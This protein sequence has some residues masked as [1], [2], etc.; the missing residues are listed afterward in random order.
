MRTGST[1]ATWRPF[2]S[3][4]VLRWAC[5]AVLAT[6]FIFAGCAKR[7]TAIE[8][9]TREN[10]LL[11]GNGG[12]PPD[13]DPHLITGIPESNI[14]LSLFEGLVRVDPSDL[15]PIPGIAK[16]WDIS[17][18]G[19]TYTFHLRP[20]ARWS[21][22]APV[23]AGD[24]YESFE[25]VLAPAFASDL[26][27]QLYYIS[28]ARE[29]NLGRQPDFSKVGLR[30]LDPVTLEIRLEH[31]TPFFL[32]LLSERFSLPVPVAVLRRF[33]GLLKRHSAWTRP[34]NMVSDGP[35]VL[36]AWIPNQLVEVARSPTYWGRD[37]VRL[38][39]VRFF[40]I[41][42]QVAEEEAFRAGQLHVTESV[43]IDRIAVYRAGNSPLLRMA[44]FSAVYYYMMNVHRPPF[45]DVRVRRALAMALDRDR[46][47]EDVTRAGETPAYTFVRN[48][49]VGGYVSGYR[50]VHDVD[51][52]RQL[53]AEAGYPGGR[54]FPKVSLL[55]NTSEGHRA[56][57]EAIQQIWRKSLNVDIDLY[58]QEWKVYLDN[59]HMKNFQI[60]RSGLV[61]DPYD[62]YQYLRVF[63][64]GFGYNDTG[65]SSPEYDRLIEE[66]V[67]LPDRDRRLALYG[68]AEE[69]LLRDMPIIP[70]YF[71]THHYLLHEEVR[72]W[73][74]NMVG[75]LP[76]GQAWLQE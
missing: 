35:F 67:A 22:G 38:G 55:Y 28:G 37:H 26:A 63:E 30:V 56:I 11:V 50:I 64:T 51:G 43:P 76:L 72:D 65:W 10:V 5:P 62:P 41:E 58:N 75:N 54:G 3:P 57:A 49:L 25:R 21:D 68:K 15:R 39:G 8:T 74:D 47:V 9:A 36:K 31:P 70:I 4:G 46:L 42:E 59:L 61:I 20:E 14:V 16:S 13:L 7:Q 2:D 24:F 45:D 34:E 71:Y 32:Q 1:I 53:L 40:P 17:A 66:A 69:I 23:T 27:D 48:G 12:D 19:K 60:C 33:G 73:T 29:F 44:P 18:D 6:A 52:A